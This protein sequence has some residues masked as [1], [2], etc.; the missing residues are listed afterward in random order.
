MENNIL[1]DLII[2][3]VF[4]VN[5]YFSNK[6][7]I[8]KRTDRSCWAF[9]LKYEGETQYTCKGKKY[10]SNENS[11]VLLPKGSSYECVCL[12]TG[13]F[14][15]IEFD[16]DQTF[17]EIMTFSPVNKELVL[18]I[19]KK[20]ERESI[21]NRKY[22]RIA[23]LE[24]VYRIILMLLNSSKKAYLPSSKK[25]K[26]K[27]VLIYIAENYNHNITNEELAKLTPYSTVYFRK[28]F[29][30]TT[31]MSPITYIHTLRIRKAK[32]MLQSDYGSVSDIAYALGYTN[33]Y[34][35]SRTFKKYTGLSP[36]HYLKFTPKD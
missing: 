6:G 4:S 8:V 23:C 27:D 17:E 18:N 3:N 20:L 16:C 10:I 36:T 22:Y 33:I 29:T 11:M 1:S 21:V 7:A 35:F 25:E 26:L 31:G 5:N 9:I 15:T 14:I 32:E 19:F 2:K 13:H 12:E 34:E 24:Q 28:L 30:E